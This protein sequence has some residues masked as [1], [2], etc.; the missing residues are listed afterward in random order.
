MAIARQLF[1]RF[2]PRA[3]HVVLLAA[4]EDLKGDAARKTTAC[5]RSAAARW[6]AKSRRGAPRHAG[7]GRAAGHRNHGAA[8]AHAGRDPR[9]QPR[10]SAGQ[11]GG[12]RYSLRHA[13]RFR[14]AAGEWARADYTV[15]FTAPKPATCWRRIAIAWANWRGPDRQPAGAVRRVWLSLWSSRRCSARCWRR[16]RARAQRHLR[17]CA[18]GRRLARQDRRRGHVRHG[19]L[20]AGAGLVTVASAAS[21]IP[22]IAAHARS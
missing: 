19:A 13:Q 17:P 20:R 11:S 7:G 5:C 21:A 18:G 8:T 6:R 16:A 12:R 15:T 22:V 10:L 9:D 3:L 2:Q 1:T 4:P 14:R